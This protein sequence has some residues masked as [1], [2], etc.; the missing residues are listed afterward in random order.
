[1]TGRARCWRIAVAASLAVAAVSAAGAAGTRGRF[2][3]WCVRGRSIG[4][5]NGTFFIMW[6][7]EQDSPGWR[8]GALPSAGGAGWWRYEAAVGAGVMHISLWLPALAALNIAA[9]SAWR[10]LAHS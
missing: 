5:W 6:T 7:L 9:L 4:L 8:S 3:Y 10:A 1:M 2:E